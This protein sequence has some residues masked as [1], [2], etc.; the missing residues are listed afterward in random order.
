MQNEVIEPT[1]K[2]L[3]DIMK[4]CV[5]AKS[6]RRIVF[7][8][9]AGTVDVAEQP[10]AFYD[11]NCWSD[12]EF[13]RRV[14]MTGWVSSFYHLKKLCCFLCSCTMQNYGSILYIYH[15]SL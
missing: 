2:G 11:E 12:V 3:L 4:A 10:K 8:S 6:V 13:C 7:T 15:V 9:S 1:I 14:K 5:K